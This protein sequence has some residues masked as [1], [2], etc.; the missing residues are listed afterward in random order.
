MIALYGVL[1]NPWIVTGIGF[2]EST[3]QA[4]A[5]VG[6]ATAMA[7]V[8]APARAGA[9]Q[10]L[11]RAFGLVAATIASAFSGLVY[12]DHGAPW[13]FFGTV[14][15]VGVVSIAGLLLLRGAPKQT[16]ASQNAEVGRT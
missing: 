14:A 15:I 6:A 13:L 7:Q 1:T 11:L 10:G 2:V 16:A 5:F 8:V 9:S 4:L 12:A 3:G